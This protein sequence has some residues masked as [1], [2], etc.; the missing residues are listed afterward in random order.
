MRV[1]LLAVF[2]GGCA[3]VQTLDA[4]KVCAT[5]DV[6][7]T[8][9]GLQTGTMIEANPLTKALAVGHSVAGT[10][11]PLIGLSIAGY[12][13]LKYLNEPRVTGVVNVLTCGVAINNAAILITH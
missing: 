1:L 8:A 7:T 10:V 3:S 9:V 6:V 13:I 2:L 12:Y 11:I 5:A 4:Y